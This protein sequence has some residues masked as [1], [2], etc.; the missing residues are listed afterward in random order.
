MVNKNEVRVFSKRRRVVFTTMTNAS[1]LASVRSF[2][3]NVPNRRRLWVGGVRFDL[4][5]G[6]SV[7]SLWNF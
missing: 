2:V 4:I 5:A 3:Q 1:R 6:H 7:V